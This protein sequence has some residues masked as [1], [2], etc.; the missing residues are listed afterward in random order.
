MAGL[1]L[2]TPHPA[3]ALDVKIVVV[4]TLFWVEGGCRSVDKELS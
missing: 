1:L 2:Y 4:V 3:L